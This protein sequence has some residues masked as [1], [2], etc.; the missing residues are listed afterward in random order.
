MY[1]D[2]LTIK[3]KIVY[4]ESNRPKLD[5]NNQNNNMDSF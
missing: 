5:H 4:G 2:N 3:Y 1:Q